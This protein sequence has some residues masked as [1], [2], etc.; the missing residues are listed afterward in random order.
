[1]SKNGA[2]KI[3]MANS[4]TI[5]KNTF[6]MY[7]RMFMMLLIGLYTSRVV[8][9]TLGVADYG[10]Y[11]V[12]GGLVGMFSIISS[13]FSTSI[14]RFLT[15]EIGHGDKEKLK[16]IFSTAVFVQ[17][18]MAIG[19]LVI[20]EI[21]GCWFL[22]YKMNIPSDR[23]FAAN[24]VLHCSIITFVVGLVASPYNA[25]IIAHERFNFFT[26]LTIFDAVF[27]LLIVF[28]LG[29]S[30]FD[31]LKL[32]AILLLLV[33]CVVQ[34]VYY[35]Y[36]RK[37][38]EE[39]R[40][41]CKFDK[42]LFKELGG[43]AGWS[44]FG[45]ASWIINTQGIDI[46]INMFFGVT[47]NAARGIANQIT[48]VVQG[49]V[50]NFMVA[51]NPQITKSYAQQD[52]SYLQKLVFAGAK[53]S[54]FLM[55]FF[56]IPLCLET[57]QILVLW[58]KIIPEY[59]VPFVRFSLV[60]TM[61]FVLGNT[62]TTSQSASGK[63]KKSAI[64][65]SLFTFLEFPFVYFCFKRGMGPISC[66][67]IHIVIY[68]LLVFV[69]IWL[70]K[71]YIYITYFDYC[72]EVLFKVFLVS[73]V[74]VILPLVCYL[75]LSEGVLRLLLVIA[76]SVCMSIFSI[77]LLGMNSKERRQIIIIVVNKIKK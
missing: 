59:G 17:V 71:Q 27:K 67:V 9:N 23:L 66:Y 65:T 56:S 22:N 13:S 60:S 51:M 21:A 18:V 2:E 40:V 20:M 35:I 63:I 49:F 37:H 38:F 46:L 77:C 42:G 44:F 74:S 5:A 28:L 52:Y 69:K 29:I 75:F 50:S 25:V 64:V 45:N 48:S 7:I 31:K 54:F 19:M 12:V 47:L 43:F 26:Y 10:I 70:V 62:L 1:M 34:I 68:F 36:C 6:I 24:I 32:Y 3:K 16:N 15:Y 39:C 73:I 11:N 55:L 30:Y 4:N 8:L 53:Y 76:V 58:L 41:F 61:I 14:S 33:S 57:K 72:K